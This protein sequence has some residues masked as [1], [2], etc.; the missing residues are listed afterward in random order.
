VNGGLPP[1]LLGAGG[2]SSRMGRPKHALAYHGASWLDWQ[3][4]RFRAA[5]GTRVHVVLPDGT[6]PP[7]VVPPGLQVDWLFQPDPAAP[8]SASLG[9]AAAAVLAEGWAAA[10]WLPVD[11]PAPGPDLWRDLWVNWQ[12]DVHQA[13]VPAAGGHPVLL[14]Q[15]LLEQLAHAAPESGLRL[16]QLLRG[17][18]PPEVLLRGSVRDANCR[19]NLNTPAAWEDWLRGEAERERE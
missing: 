9:L 3:L 13:A 15:G 7:A 16:D 17:L 4:T 18:D 14:G 10:W 6:A 11:V 2:R 5:G 1:L 12:A 8:M 19:L